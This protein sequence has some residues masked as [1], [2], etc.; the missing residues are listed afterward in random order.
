MLSR[1]L[2]S[3]LLIMFFITIPNMIFAQAEIAFSLERNGNRDL[4]IMDENGENIRR[5]T[6]SIWD[7]NPSWSPD[8]S[9]IAFCRIVLIPEIWVIDVNTGEEWDLTIGYSPAWSPDGTK[10]AFVGREVGINS[11]EICTISIDGE[12][13]EKL[14]NSNMPGA[15]FGISWTDDGKEIVHTRFDRNFD[16]YSVDVESQ[17]VKK[18]TSTQFN[19]VFPSCSPSGRKIAFSRERQKREAIWV[20]DLE[21][22]E[23]RMLTDENFS[24]TSPSWSPDGEKIIFSSDIGGQWDLWVIREDGTGLTQLTDSPE[25]EHEPSWWNPGML[26]ISPSGKLSTTWGKLKGKVKKE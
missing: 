24:S 4:Y 21:S 7:E 10:I 3:Y 15:G 5:L 12:E 8:K 16:I 17:W 13:K 14:T 25:R 6:K 18:L 26:S 11:G 23:E 1:I 22:K 2:L 19:D 9:K 20:I